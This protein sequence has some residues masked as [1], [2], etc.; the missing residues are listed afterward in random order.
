M[1]SWAGK[2]PHGRTCSQESRHMDSQRIYGLT[3]EIMQ[4]HSSGLR[5]QGDEHEAA[6]ILALTEGAQ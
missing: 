3:A 4:K 1:M 2:Y 5:F 6:G